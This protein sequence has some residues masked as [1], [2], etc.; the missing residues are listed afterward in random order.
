MQTPSADSIRKGWWLLAAALEFLFSLSLPGSAIPGPLGTSYQVNVDG[1][2]QNIPGDAANE[3]SLCLDPNNPSRI[4][5]GW[6]QFNSTNNNFRQAG[7]AFSTNGGTSWTFGGVLQ[8]NVFRSD[9]VLAADAEGH[10]YYLSL[11]QSNPYRC[12]LWQ[13]SDGGTSWQLLGPAL[14]GDKSWMTIDRTSGP[15]HGNI[16]QA[17]DS[18]SDTGLLDFSVSYDGGLSWMTPIE[19]PQNP[20]WGTLDVGPGGELYYIAWDPVAHQFWLNRSTN[21][22][23]QAA[24]FSFDLT[25]S[26]NFGGTLHYYLGYGPNPGGLLGQPWVAVDRS[27]NMTRGNVYALF[28][29]GRTAN[30]CDVMFTRS[31]DG[32]A[33]W[34]PPRQLNDDPGSNAW[35]W[36][37]TLSVAPNGRLDACWYDTRSDPNHILSRLYYCYSMNGGVS[38]TTNQALS[39][40]FNPLLGWPQQNKIGDYLGMVSLDEAA[41]IA[42]SA[43]FNGEEDVY[44]LRAEQP[45]VVTIAN[46]GSLLRFSWN[47]LPGRTYCLQSKDAL[48]AAWP[49]TGQVCVTATNALMTLSQPLAPGVAQ[50]FYRVFLQP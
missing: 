20:E 4:A 27:T 30:S 34:S 33:T 1:N 9:P 7:W 35:H 29:A 17:W 40:A 8:T 5:V 45:L 49:T 28:S 14:G 47:A 13:S 3:P 50:Q 44:F 31:T 48:T 36:F 24:P 21:A 42:Y 37:G 39:P 41:C 23:N 11:L 12:D 26:V 2:G 22:P 43:T 10:F 15:G 18:F 32:G 16:Y 25:V 6:R 38:W 19:V 46:V